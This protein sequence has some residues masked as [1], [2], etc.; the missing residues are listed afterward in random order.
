MGQE[1]GLRLTSQATP[2]WGGVGRASGFLEA[3][4]DSRE[5]YSL[6]LWKALQSSICLVLISLSLEQILK[7]TAL[8]PDFQEEGRIRLR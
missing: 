3:T 1:K 8:S 7:E 4:V 6:W 5:T 2:G